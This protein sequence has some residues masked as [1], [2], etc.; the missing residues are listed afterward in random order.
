M[1]RLLRIIFHRQRQSR[2]IGYVTVEGDIVLGIIPGI[3]HGD[4]AIFIVL[5]VSI[6][7]YGKLVHFSITVQFQY[8]SKLLADTACAS[9]SPLPL[10]GM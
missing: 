7:H 2:S 8:P 6:H 10:L 4:F 3:A 5:P 1:L 9:Q